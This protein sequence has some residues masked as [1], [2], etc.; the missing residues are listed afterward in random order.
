MPKPGEGLRKVER[1]D[2]L[3]VDPEVFAGQLATLAVD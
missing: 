3:A 2:L 1:G